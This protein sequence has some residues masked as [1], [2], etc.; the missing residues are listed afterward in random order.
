MACDLHGLNKRT[1][2]TLAYNSLTGSHIIEINVDNTLEAVAPMHTLTI[3]C[4]F[5][6]QS[7]LSLAL[8]VVCTCPM[9]PL[10]LETNVHFVSSCK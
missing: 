5:L 3:F 6:T 8:S 10:A 2:Y 9:E 1:K 4:I 7:H